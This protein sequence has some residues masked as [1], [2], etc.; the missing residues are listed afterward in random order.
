[1]GDPWYGLGLTKNGKWDP[2][3]TYNS[4]RDNDIMNTFMGAPDPKKA[5]RTLEAWQTA[6]DY[7]NAAQNNEWQYDQAQ[8]GLGNLAESLQN[9]ISSP[10]APSVAREQLAQTLQANTSAQGAAASGIGGQNAYMARRNAANNVASLNAK[11]GQDASLLRAQEVANAQQGLAGALGT[12]MSGAGNMYNTKTNTGLGYANNATGNANASTAANAQQAQGWKDLAVGAGSLMS[13]PRA[14]DGIEN[15][16]PEA[17]EHFLSALQ[18]SE[19]SYKDDDI[20]EPRRHGI[21]TTDLKRSEIGKS[22]VRQRSDGYEEVDG[23][24][25]LGAALAA[26]GHMHRRV[27][28]LEGRGGR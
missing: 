6:E 22:L 23:G 26:L 28:A 15:E 3:G 17:I 20:S 7:R 13:D 16:D 24:Q 27:S 10:A 11:A 9:T 21:M 1:M 18:P 19:F 12:Q 4:L 14:K 8:A 25:G 2:P 5:E